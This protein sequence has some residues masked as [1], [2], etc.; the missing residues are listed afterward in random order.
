MSHGGVKSLIHYPKKFLRHFIS[1]ASPSYNY[2]VIFFAIY[3]MYFKVL[4]LLMKST[5]FV[6]EFGIL[7]VLL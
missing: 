4:K 1:F 5:K 2:I 3:L 6:L 7:D